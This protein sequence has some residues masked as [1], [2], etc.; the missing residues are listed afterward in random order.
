MLSHNGHHIF[1]LDWSYQLDAI[2][3]TLT[4][5]LKKKDGKWQITEVELLGI[6]RASQ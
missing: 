4:W 6:G 1:P 3:I 2:R 5:T